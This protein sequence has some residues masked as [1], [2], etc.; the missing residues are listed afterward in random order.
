MN[1]GTRS[2]CASLELLG[3]EQN[4]TNHDPL[5]CLGSVGT[6]SLK[7]VMVDCC[8]AAVESSVNIIYL[9]ALFIIYL[10]AP[11]AYDAG[12]DNDLIHET[13]LHHFS[14]QNPRE[15]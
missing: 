9:T 3:I 8:N 13:K 4:I 2:V 5:C 10:T 6:A 7:I 14:L 1:T 15:P 11:K 12:G